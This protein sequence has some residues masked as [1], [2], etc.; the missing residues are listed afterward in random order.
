MDKYGFIFKGYFDLL[1]YII[2][3]VLYPSLTI[4]L[5]IVFFQDNSVAELACLAS[6]GFFYSLTFYYDFYSRYRNCKNQDY[7]TSW[8]LFHG[9]NL[10]AAIV[11]YLLGVFISLLGIFAYKRQ[12]DV[13]IAKKLFYVC[14]ISSAYPFIIAIIDLVKM[15]RKERSDSKKSSRP[16]GYV[17]ISKEKI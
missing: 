17:S 6:T 3:A 1:C 7:K 4:F 12:I 5:Q 9:R 13:V 10:F 2:I 8:K 15:L 11:I 14:P 16:Q